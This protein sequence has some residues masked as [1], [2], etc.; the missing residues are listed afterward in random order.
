MKRSTTLF[1]LCL[2]AALFACGG[3]GDDDNS[4][5]DDDNGGG[6]DSGLSTGAI[7]T[8]LSDDDLVE[9]CDWN[10]DEL[11]GEGH[12]TEC[13]DGLTATVGSSAECVS[14]FENKDCALT[15][16]E[17]ED[18][19]GALADDPCDGLESQACAPFFTCAVEG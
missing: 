6:G 5:D 14:S 2:A 13:G 7:V 10:I 15:V 16:G 1:G 11:G 8:D 4:G 19:T 17:F 18:C 12:E 9:L 3:G